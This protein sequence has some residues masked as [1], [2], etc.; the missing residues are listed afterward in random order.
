[1]LV[2]LVPPIWERFVSA[3]KLA[4]TISGRVIS[5]PGQ[6]WC[7]QLHHGDLCPLKQRLIFHCWA[8]EQ[9]QSPAKGKKKGSG[10]NGRSAKW[11]NLQ[12]KKKETSLPGLCE[13]L[14]WPYLHVSFP[15]MDT[16]SWCL[17][18][19]ATSSSARCPCPWQGGCSWMIFK[20]PSNHSITRIFLL[21]Q[22]SFLPAYLQPLDTHLCC[23]PW[24]PCSVCPA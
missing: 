1:M 4:A 2:R 5:C 18:L 6:H 23:H 19:G 8:L 22:L 16:S 21:L 15:I 17:E 9:K 11:E 3:S 24:C 13:E 20:V 12:K 10:R 7:S 14:L